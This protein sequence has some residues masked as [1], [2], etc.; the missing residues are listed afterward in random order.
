MSKE[1]KKLTI[2]LKIIKSFLI[3]ER[4]GCVSE[5]KQCTNSFLRELKLKNRLQNK[6]KTGLKQNILQICPKLTKK[7]KKWFGSFIFIL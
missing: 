5:A 3:S 4:H 1:R 2:M 7:K 6:F